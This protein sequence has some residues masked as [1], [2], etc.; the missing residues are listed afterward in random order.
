MFLKCYLEILLPCSGLYEYY[1]GPAA[2][3][4]PSRDFHY[5]HLELTDV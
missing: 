4:L 5:E 1:P 3:P 2:P